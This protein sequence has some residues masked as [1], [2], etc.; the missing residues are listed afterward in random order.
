LE[1]AV[2]DT[3][4]RSVINTK[5]I[6]SGGERERLGNLRVGCCR[7]KSTFSER[8]KREPPPGGG[9]SPVVGR[10][11][12]KEKETC[13][14]DAGREEKKKALGRKNMAELSIPMKRVKINMVEIRESSQ[15]N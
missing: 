10:N 15:Q 11:H 1:G 4:I 13:G 2:N 9:A 8:A 14:G 3:I 12:R 6:V 5:K 7:G